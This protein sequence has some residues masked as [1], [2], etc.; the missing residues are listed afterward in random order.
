MQSVRV[1]GGVSPGEKR[2]DDWQTPGEIFCPLD[3]QFFFWIDMAATRGN[4]R[5]PYFLDEEIDALSIPWNMQSLR[6]AV[7]QDHLSVNPL[8]EHRVNVWLNPPY[9]NLEPWI[10][11]CIEG[12]ANGL[13]IVALLPPNVDQKWFRKCILHADC[14]VYNGRIKFVDPTEKK[15]SAPGKGNLLAIFRPALPEGWTKL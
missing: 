5:A 4:H 9:T 2:R 7:K 3:D 10:D 6:Q 14:Y 13:T 15:R 8:P 12:A 11:K 1:S